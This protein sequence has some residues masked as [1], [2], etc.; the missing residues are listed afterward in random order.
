MRSEMKTLAES[1]KTKDDQLKKLA[2][3]KFWKF[4]KSSVFIFARFQILEYNKMAKDVHRSTYTKR[5]LEIVANIKKQKQD[6]N[7]VQ[8]QSLNFQLSTLNLTFCFRIDFSRY[9]GSSKRH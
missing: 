6:I 7:K 3:L 8:K 2:S 4:W 1:A 9:E 5:I